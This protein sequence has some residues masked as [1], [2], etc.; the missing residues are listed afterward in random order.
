METK[1]APNKTEFIPR[2]YQIDLF[3]KAVQD[4]TILYL[5]TGAGKT[6]IAVM[7]LKHL[8]ADIRK[9][10][11][12]DGKR[13]IFVVN[14]VALVLQHSE[15]IKR[16]TDL[17][18]RGYSGD[19]QIDYWEEEQ[20]LNEIE[21]NQVLVM[22]AQIFL[23]LLSHGY[24]KLEKV[25]LIVFDE[26]HRAVSNH[27]MRQIMQRFEDCPKDKQ[28]HVLAMSATLLNANIKLDKIESTI[29][30]L[31]T[32]FQ[33][34]IA[35][36]ESADCIEGYCT[37]PE[38]SIVIYMKEETSQVIDKVTQIVKTVGETLQYINL[39][40]DDLYQES[41]KEMRPKAKCT[42]L[43]AIIT[44]I[45][46]TTSQTGI[47]GGSKS[48]L[49][50]LI[51][52]ES[53][54]KYCNDLITNNVLDYMITQVIRIRKL[55][56]IEM[57]GYIEVEQLHHFTS[58]QIHKLF[59]TL[60][61]CND[62]LL[63]NQKFCCIIFVKER[64]MTQVIYHILKTLSKLDEKY[65][66]LLPDY[67]VGFQNNP[68]KYS[69]E[70]S[71][72]AT[73]NKQVLQRFKTGSSNCIVATDV[74]DEGIDVPNCTL[75]IRFDIPM[76]FR[77]YV[78]SKGRARHSSSQ[79]IILMP[80]ND[81]EFLQRYQSYKN[82]EFELKSSLV[83]QSELRKLPTDS[84]ISK[85]LY[86]NE[87]EPYVVKRNDGTSCITEISAIGVINMYCS[88]LMKTKFVHLVPIWKLD[89]DKK[90]MYKVS[91][92][93][94]IVSPLK[95]E[96]HGD[97]MKSIDN[98]KRSAA[99]KT[100]INLHKLGALTDKLLPA[101]GSAVLQNLNY[102]FP[103]WIDEDN[104][105][106]GTYKRKR[107]HK[108]EHPM[109][110]YSAFPKSFE[111]LVLHVLH[112]TPTYPMMS[113]DNRRIIFYKLLNDKSSFG[114]LSTK[115]MPKIPSFPIF[116]KDGE[117]DVDVQT[118]YVTMV[119]SETDI[120]SLKRFHFLLFGEV[121]SV[122]KN[123]MLFDNEN[124]E[125]SFLI[126]PLNDRQEIKWDVVRTYQHI[127]RIMPSKPFHFR[128]SDYELALVTPTYRGSA[129]V[130]IVTR[131][132]DD[133]TPESC[134][135]NDD[136][137]TFTHY[138]KEK[139]GLTI[140]NLQ[141]SMLEVKPIPI[142]IDY[143]KPR[144]SHNGSAK[145][146]KADDT[147]EDLQEHL[148]PELCWKINFP[149][150]Y[151]LKATTLPSILHRISQLLIAE[152]LRLTI[153]SEAKL[154]SLTLEKLPRLTSEKDNVNL[155]E[156][157]F[158]NESDVMMDDVV[159]KTQSDLNYMYELNDYNPSNDKEPQD[160][161]R[162]MEQVQ[163]LDIQYYNQFISANHDDNIQKS[164]NKGHIDRRTARPTVSVPS[165]NILVS[166][167]KRFFS[168]GPSVIEIMHAL[169]TKLG[170]D[171][172]NL[173]RLETLGD[174]CLKF[175]TSLFLYHKFPAFNE[176]Q[177]T[178]VKGKIIGNRNLYYCGSKKNIPGRIKN[179]AFVP[180]S[181]FIAPAYTVLRPLQEILLNESVAPNVLYEIRI[182]E[183]EK[184]TGYISEDTKCIMQQTVMNWDKEDTRT[185]Y[186]HYL[187]VQIL[188]DKTIA[189]SV[190][191]LIGV[192]LESN[193]IKGA[194]E[195]LKWF[196]ILPDVKIDELLYDNPPDPLIGSGNPNTYMPWACDMETKIGY[197]FNNRAFLLQAFTHPSYM[198]NGITECYQRLEFIGDAILDFLITCYIYET[199]GNLSPGELTDLRSALVNNTTF[200]CVAVRHALDTALLAYA[201]KLHEAI[202]RF[203]KFQQERNYVVNDDLLYVLL[204]EEECE[205]AEYVDVPKVLGD[206]FES[207]IGAIYLDS[208][209]NLTKVWEIIYSFMHKE[210]DKFSKNTPKHPV[211]LIHENTD[212]R[213]KFL[214]AVLIEGTDT[215]MVPLKITIAG[216]EKLYH[217]FGANKKLAKCAAAKQALKRLQ[218]EK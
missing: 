28:P 135:P 77:G 173:E 144:R 43:I 84:D 31:E 95:T 74:V 161:Y 139:H 42:K 197:K 137:D 91:L 22:T 107:V 59:E 106:P 149:A 96:V 39:N 217:G 145:N 134:F 33:S 36:V 169:T 6:Y 104:Y 140:E 63:D 198:P 115:I 138:Y 80:K 166:S 121:L 109:A 83:G 34:K 191:A 12:Q 60:V 18:C 72:I 62:K 71:C 82:T 186:E 48:A 116:M 200:A 160:L 154:G 7:L 148:I 193:G 204:E 203:V 177:L 216:K 180:T 51:Q 75:I 40:I 108:L 10:Y 79:Y 188:S 132:C 8:S 52:L 93:L 151:W 209:K 99:M 85:D 101:T 111:T 165:L 215:V 11:S 133:L 1:L 213:P 207:L 208:G 30:S 67:I 117:L 89:K 86:T 131:V 9:P 146:K 98:A 114:I 163:M 103:N 14:T 87:I 102:L 23:D 73:W 206:L 17:T 129:N 150:L 46:K 27:P 168:H 185:G 159:E 187:G 174:S 4:N 167:E 164:T 78:Q 47:Y 29:K 92:K 25:N 110:L 136:F 2:A 68:Y 179:D 15:Y 201:P 20:W 143:I 112:C 184:F 205:L 45:G 37:N 49:L 155:I 141:Q 162:N 118:N 195:L 181:T 202:D 156:E 50:H 13:T 142:K 211:R 157:K 19:M 130:Y 192:Y 210:I 97:Y 176:G 53:L 126:V 44:D 158:S 61:K 16:H 125:N 196:G 183:D 214:D 5:P 54:R 21:T 76:D 58:D 170:M 66:F 127:E 88:S 189:D 124:L 26:C 199:C 120:E 119:L 56:D 57:K 153:A 172:F 147:V 178:A 32:T 69:R 41:S 94:P 35:T 81:T 90:D 123:F 212:A 3:E 122:I 24:M 100:C 55:F 152:G 171:M 190:E 70:V 175:I 65:S 218:L 128:P 182:P 113:Y 194:V 105:L 64:F 38:E